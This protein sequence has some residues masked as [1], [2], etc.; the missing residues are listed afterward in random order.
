MSLYMDTEYIINYWLIYHMLGYLNIP[1]WE[2]MYIQYK[3]PGLK[4]NL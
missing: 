4:F 3:D 1:V 2:Y